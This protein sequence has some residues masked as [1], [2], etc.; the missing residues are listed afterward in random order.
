MNSS[1]VIRAASD[2]QLDDLY[3]AARG[4]GP[5]CHLHVEPAFDCL[6]DV[7]ERFLTSPALSGAPRQLGTLRHHVPVL[8]T[9]D[10]DSNC[11]SA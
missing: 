4:F 1:T 11:H 7:R 6:A 8:A 10:H 9:I 3:L 5:G 2:G